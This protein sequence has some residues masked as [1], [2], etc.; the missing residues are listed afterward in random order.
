[1][2]KRTVLAA[3]MERLQFGEEKFI[4]IEDELV[5]KI[6]YAIPKN[7]LIVL[8]EQAVTNDDIDLAE[9]CLTQ[10]LKVDSVIQD[11]SL[12]DFALSLKRYTLAALLLYYDR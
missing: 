5:K 7:K 4:I 8:F 10:G 1:M 3:V 2:I 12:L 11:L 9:L 6:D